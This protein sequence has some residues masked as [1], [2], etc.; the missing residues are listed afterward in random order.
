V[1]EGEGGMPSNVE[2]EEENEE[3]KSRSGDKDHSVSDDYDEDDSQVIPP[4]PPGHTWDE[5]QSTTAAVADEDETLNE[6]LLT[7]PHCQPMS[8]FLKRTN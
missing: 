3:E 1:L 4:T 2:E 8:F 7:A 5:S 6:I